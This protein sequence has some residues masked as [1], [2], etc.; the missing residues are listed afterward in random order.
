M[1]EKMKR[2]V[3]GTQYSHAEMHRQYLSALASPHILDEQEKERVKKNGK[4]EI[5]TR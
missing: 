2:G 1:N 4:E 3:D 5:K